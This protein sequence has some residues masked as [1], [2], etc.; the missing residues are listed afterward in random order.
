M[1]NRHWYTISESKLRRFSKEEKDWLLDQEL[2]GNKPQ[3]KVHAWIKV[4]IVE[5][6]TQILKSLFRDFPDSLVVRTQ[7]PLQGDGFDPWS[8]N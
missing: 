6:I 8:G 7:I 5:N 4:S 1:C 3:G 2:I